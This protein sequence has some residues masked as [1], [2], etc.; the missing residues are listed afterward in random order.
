M[1]AMAMMIQTDTFED[2]CR[3]RWGMSRIHAHRLMTSAEIANN[4]L[5]I[6]NIPQTESQARPLAR[7]E[8]EQ[9]IIAWETAVSTAAYKANLYHLWAGGLGAGDASF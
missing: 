4:L 2:Y 8:P 5:P 6:G 9:Q 1:L 3:G 7:L